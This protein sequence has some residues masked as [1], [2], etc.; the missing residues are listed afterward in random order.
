MG[1]MDIFAD[2]SQFETLTMG[3]RVLGSLITAMM[4]MGTTFTVLVL[5]WGFI[6]LISRAVRTEEK[7]FKHEAGG[8]APA[9]APAPAPVAAAAAPAGDDALIAVITAAIAAAQGSAVTSNLI[10]RKIIRIPGPDPVWSNT[11]RHEAL[12]SRRV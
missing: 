2:P 10:V 4:G 5:I 11:G 8:K 9:P 6:N 3:E 7:L 1:L 12:D